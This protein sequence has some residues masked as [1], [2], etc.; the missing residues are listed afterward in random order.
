MWAADLQCT[1]TC[2]DFPFEIGPISGEIS[3]EYF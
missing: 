2:S 3:N 1:S